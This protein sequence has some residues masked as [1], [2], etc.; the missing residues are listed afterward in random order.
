MLKHSL[1]PALFL[2]ASAFAAPAAVTFHRDVEPILQKS[3]Q[4]CHRPGE[5]APM[6]LLTYEQV[7]RSPNPSN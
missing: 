4:E 3:C 2:C 5:I 7:R 6:S 1:G